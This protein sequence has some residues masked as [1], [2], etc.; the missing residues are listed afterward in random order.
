MYNKNIHTQIFAD[1]RFGV[2]VKRTWKYIHLSKVKILKYSN[3]VKAGFITCIAASHLS[4]NYHNFSC[5]SWFLFTN[6]HFLYAFQNIG[7]PG[8]KTML[9]I[10]FPGGFK[11]ETCRT[12]WILIDW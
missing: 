9:P 3:K 10:E 6:K 11:Y 12:F 4:Y 7:L 1:V 5:F 8:I 2:K